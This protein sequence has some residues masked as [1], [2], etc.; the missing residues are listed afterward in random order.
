[1]RFRW[2]S[3]LSVTCLAIALVP[4]RAIAHGSSVQYRTT[5]AIA[6]RAAF[7]SGEPMAEA[8]VT[9]FA[10]DNPTEP[11]LQGQTTANGEFSFIPDPARAG[12]WDVQVRQ[13]GHGAIVTIPEEA[14][15]AFSSSDG[16]P[17]AI[18][19]TLSSSSPSLS[20]AQIALTAAAGVWG[21]IGT[22]CFFARKES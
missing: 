15:A 12:A 17:S 20:P 18:A 13:A 6:I 7:D 16:D 9:V 5:Q 11:W 8:Q 21:C 2:F 14:I 3:F 22:A 19:A 10:P 1:M 4:S